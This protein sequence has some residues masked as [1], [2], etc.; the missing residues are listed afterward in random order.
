MTRCQRLFFLA[1]YND[2][3]YAQSEDTQELPVPCC[4]VPSYNFIEPNY[5]QQESFMDTTT[6]TVMEVDRE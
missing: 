6:A 5:I 4:N 3:T 2:L 1:W